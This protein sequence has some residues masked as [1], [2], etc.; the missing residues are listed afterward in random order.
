MSDKRRQRVSRAQYMPTVTELTRLLEPTSTTSERVRGL[1]EAGLV[2]HDV[3]V[4]TGVSVSAL[5]NWSAGQTQ[6]R[7]DAELALDD[8]R[9]TVKTLLDGGLE[10]PRAVSWLK[11]RNPE[12]FENER[13]IDVLS[14]SPM[15]VLSAA[16]CEL[17]EI[18]NERP[19][20]AAP[21]RV[22]R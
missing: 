10:A 22:V 21:L 12:Y 17:L 9:I 18:D 7:R 11:S 8:L 6:P 13:P 20:D 16:H 15:Q 14:K 5:R 4:A 3:A 1:L 19:V 2:A